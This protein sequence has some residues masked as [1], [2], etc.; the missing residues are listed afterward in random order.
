MKRILFTWELGG[1]LGHI[2]PMNYLARMLTARGCEVYLAL[3]DLSHASEVFAGTQVKLLQAPYKTGFRAN[4]IL[5]PLCF[6]H[7]L[8]NNGFSSA[9]ELDGLVRSW[10]TLFELVR[11]DVI[12]FDHSPSALVA[13]RGFDCTKL[14][15]SVGFSAPPPGRPL[16]MFVETA[17]DVQAMMTN[18]G[19]VLANINQ[20][21]AG[22]GCPPLESLDQLFYDEITHRFLSLPEFDHYSERDMAQYV[23]PVLSDSG[24]SPIW[25]GKFKKK[26]YVYLKQFPG[27]AQLFRI[28]SKI[29]A[30]FLVYT[31]N[32]PADALSCSQSGNVSFVSRPLNLSLVSETADLAIVNAGHTTL[33]QFVLAGVPVYMVPLQM[34]QQLLTIRMCKQNAGWFGDTNSRRFFQD[35]ENLLG[36]LNSGLTTKRDIQ[37]KYRDFDFARQHSR[38]CDEIIGSP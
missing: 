26:V 35:V 28:F 37:S 33:C 25:P 12:C 6:S 22:L 18:D 31:N 15:V 36:K 19:L 32:V 8:H 14:I 30:S 23:G 7:L 9:S 29:P 4:P 10:K 17:Q 5:P 2:I 38:L 21:L 1:G 11:P 27:I 24:M 16:G 3:M 13:A 20:V 34:E